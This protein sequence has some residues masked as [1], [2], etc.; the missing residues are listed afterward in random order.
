ML[1]AGLRG[2]PV[3]LAAIVDGVAW[4]QVERLA[5]T[6]FASPVTTSMGRLFD[7]VAALC[8]VCPTVNY[9]GQAAIELEALRDRSERGA[10]RIAVEERDGALELDPREAIAAIVRDVRV[11]V[12][13]GVVAARFHSGVAAATV[14]ACAAVASATGVDAVVLSGGVFQNRTLLEGVA[15]G[16]EGKGLRVRLPERLPANDGGICYGQAA[17]AARRMAGVAGG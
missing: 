1:E 6:G 9:D 12:P 5:G 7:A 15:S 11:G 8:G 4:A 14:E 2:P 17:V 13:V 16:L 10:Y 3:P